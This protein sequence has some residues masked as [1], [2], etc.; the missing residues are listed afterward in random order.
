MN[1]LPKT[2]DNTWIVPYSI[3]ECKQ[4]VVGLP[5]RGF[6]RMRTTTEFGEGDTYNQPFILRRV[7]RNI[8]AKWLALSS[9][10]G[11]FIFQSPTSTQVDYRVRANWW[12]YTALIPFF[13]IF[14]LF[15]GEFGW[16]IMGIAI[17]FSLIQ[18]F[19]NVWLSQRYMKRQLRESLA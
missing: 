1:E 6:S 3:D 13:A 5:E 9:L 4:R 11:N 7:S 12:F 2:E 16:A 14:L 8:P 17:A 18:I 10:Q 19:V 15:F